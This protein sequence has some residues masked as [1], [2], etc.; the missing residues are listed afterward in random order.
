M[1]L[2][3]EGLSVSVDLCVIVGPIGYVSLHLYECRPGGVC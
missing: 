2:M 1:V 3:S